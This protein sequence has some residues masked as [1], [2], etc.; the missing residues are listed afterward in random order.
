MLHKSVPHLVFGAI[1]QFMTMPPQLLRALPWLSVGR[2]SV[3]DLEGLPKPPVSLLGKIFAPEAQKMPHPLNPETFLKFV[4]SHRYAVIHFWAPWNERDGLMNGFLESGI[5]GK[6]RRQ[7]A[8]AS[9]NID[10]PEH[11]ELVRQHKVFDVP[12]IAFYRDGLLVQTETGGC[13]FGKTA[14]HLRELV[15]G[16]PAG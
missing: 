15:S 14:K 10:V 16:N 11:I 5:P 7:I 4:V 8:F 13:G 1:V 6:L 9:F 2:H 12:L 3:T